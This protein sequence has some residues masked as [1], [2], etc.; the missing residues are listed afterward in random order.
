VATGLAAAGV[1]FVAVPVVLAT[2]V[3]V[4]LPRHWTGRAVLSSG[5]ALDLL[6]VV[7][8]L[9]WASCCR[10]MLSSIAARVRSGNT[11]AGGATFPDWLA[12]RIAASILV[13]LPVGLAAAM[14]A[15]AAGPGGVRARPPAVTAGAPAYGDRSGAVGAAPPAPGSAPAGPATDATPASPAVVPLPSTYTVVAGDTLWSIAERFYSDGGDWSLIARWNLGHVMAGDTIFTDPALIEPGWVL[16]LPA[17][18]A[19]PVPT[20][21][22]AAP[23]APAPARLPAA[24]IDDHHAAPTSRQLHRRPPAPRPSPVPLPELAALGVGTLVAAGLARR[25]RRARVLSTLDRPE[26]PERLRAQDTREKVADAAV[27]L[28]PFDGALVLDQVEA[29]DRILADALDRSGRAGDAPAVRLVRAGPDGVELMLSTPVDWAPDPWERPDPTT[30]L[31]PPAMG[32]AGVHSGAGDPWIPSLVAVGD[33]DLGSWLVPVGAGAVLPVLGSGADELVDTLRLAA[34]SWSWADR[35]TVTDDAGSVGR[36]TGAAGEPVLYFG[37]P[38]GLTD[39]E[40]ARCG[41]VTTTPSAATD[42][43]LVVDDRGL[44]VHPLGVL[45][46]PHRLDAGLRGAA[47]EISQTPSSAGPRAAPARPSLAPGP[48]EVRLLTSIPRI[49]GLSGELTPKRARRVIELVAYLALHH[50]DVVTSDRLRNRVLGSADADA[51]AKTLFNTAGAARRALGCSASGEPYLP[52]ATKSGHYRISGLVTVDADRAVALVAA[53]GDAEPRRAMALLREAL[54]LVEGEPL[55]GTLNGFAWWTAEGHERRT[56]AALVEGACRL[57]R[58]A[59]NAGY[60][61]LARWAVEQA[62]LVEPSSESLSRAAMEVAAEAGD[63]DALRREW[64]D[65]RRRVDEID[66]GSCPAPA[67][68]QLYTEL[69]SSRLSRASVSA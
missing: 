28:A 39:E 56:S 36:S 49:D 41:I 61:D 26:R 29:A 3:G 62:R 37:D 8:W 25:A 65:C 58:L 43:T 55:A 9:A 13:L 34:E 19:T 17:P 57:A 64:E 20:P 10:S 52:L 51:A 35:L 5:G 23:A 54:S 53:A 48:V 45:L 1:L 7:A 33:N 66:P 15:G 12:T 59:A 31:L 40:R 50:P 16:N 47:A 69:R 27:L 68:E 60:L 18:D 46:R 4:P 11:G 2:V 21:T 42:L 67:T 38:A 32:A 14:P 22:T 63:S 24:R 6:S 30:W 44:T